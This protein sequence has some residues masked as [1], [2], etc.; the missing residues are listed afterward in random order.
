MAAKYLAIAGILKTRLDSGDYAVD[1]IPGER[2]IA[3]ELGVSHM[4]ARKA[5]QYLIAQ[6]VVSKRPAGRVAR[7]RT[8]VRPNCQLHIAFI[9]PAFDSTTTQRWRLALD[10]LVTA[11]QGSLRQVAYVSAHDPVITDALEGEF[12]GVFLIPPVGI[13]SLLI[14]RLAAERGRVVTL[15]HDLTEYGIPCIDMNSPASIWRIAQHLAELG[16]KRVDCLNTQPVIPLIERRITAWEE[17]AARFGI[18]TVVHRHEVASF[19]HPDLRAYE[20]VGALLDDPAYDSVTGLFCTT[21][22]A[23]RG[24]V[25]AAYVRKV[26]VGK[27]LSLAAPDGY[28]EARLATPS[29]TTLEDPDL[30]PYLSRGIDWLVTGGRDWDGPLR[31]QPDEIPLWVGESTGVPHPR[32]QG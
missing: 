17:A 21:T 14:K 13:S 23:C 31:I 11:R 15:F 25:R 3:E 8:R 10:R 16:H 12:D 27:G 26:Q 9:A 32:R 5:V 6:G 18:E 30:T 19:D 1:G 2:R 24:A 28:I 7:A 29:L 20:V 4:T 22:A